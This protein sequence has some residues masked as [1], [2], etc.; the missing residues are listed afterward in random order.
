MKPKKN[1]VIL[2]VNLSQKDSIKVGDADFQLVPKFTTNYR[3][4]NPV[5]GVVVDGGKAIKKGTILVCHHNL[6]REDSPFRIFDDYFSIPVNRNI[7]L[8][9]DEN[10]EPHGMYGNV[11][12]ERL[13]PESF[14]D[15]PTSYKKS[16]DNRVRI[17]ENGEGLLKGDEVLMLK[18][19]DYQCV[20]MWNGIEKRVIRLFFEDI[21]AVIEK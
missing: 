11:V 12:A 5:A 7:F 15:I 17:L 6:F 1:H 10:G 13:E 14:F 16:I 9:I 2:K 3:E 20:Y 8:R 18:W 4:K 19:G 21:V